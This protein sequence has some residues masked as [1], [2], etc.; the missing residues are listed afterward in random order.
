MGR[1]VKE[2]KSVSGAILG[3]VILMIATFFLLNWLGSRNL[4]PVSGAANWAASHAN[5]TA[6]SGGGAP[7]PVGPAVAIP[8]SYSAGMGPAL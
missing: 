7:G 3:L 6:Y 4:G 5:G 1:L 2:A 8:T